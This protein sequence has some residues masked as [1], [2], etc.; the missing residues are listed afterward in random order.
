MRWIF[1]LHCVGSHKVSTTSKFQQL[2]ASK[3]FQFIFIDNLPLL[4]SNFYNNS[5]KNQNKN[6]R[7]QR[8]QE[9]RNHFG[10]IKE[11]H[12]SKIVKSSKVMDRWKIFPCGLALQPS[13]AVRVLLCRAREDQCTQERESKLEKGDEFSG[14]GKV[15]PAWLK[16]HQAV[17][18]SHLV[19]C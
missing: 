9:K 12:Y 14:S 6:L 18:F 16:R 7:H 4:F 3:I 2:W 1:W 11:I 13:A 17:A 8:M 10:N 19:G 15:L 5:N